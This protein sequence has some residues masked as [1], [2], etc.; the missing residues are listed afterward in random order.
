MKT[1]FCILLFSLLSSNTFAQND[2]QLDTKLIQK[3][4][5]GAGFVIQYEGL[6]DPFISESS[7]SVMYGFSLQRNS[8][9]S[10]SYIHDAKMPLVKLTQTIAPLSNVGNLDQLLEATISDAVG[11]LK[12]LSDDPN[13]ELKDATDFTRIIASTS[14]TGK[15]YKIKINNLPGFLECYAFKDESGKGIGVTVKYLEESNN[16]TS[17]NETNQVDDILDD[18][19]IVSIDENTPYVYQLAQYPLHF[20][21]YSKIEYAK[22]LN[23]SAVE[24]KVQMNGVSLTLQL[25]NIPQ[26]YSTFETKR[27]QINSHET[28]LKDQEMQGT[29]TRNWSAKTH[30][31][32]GSDS[33]DLVEGQ[34]Y[35]YTAN[36]QTIFNT[37][38]TQLNGNLLVIANFTAPEENYRGVLRY[39]ATLFKNSAGATRK[40]QRQYLFPGFKLYLPPNHH[41]WKREESERYD[42]YLISN[43]STYQFDEKFNSVFSRVPVTRLK[44]YGLGE[45]QSLNHS[46]AELLNELMNRMKADD[47]PFEFYKNDEFLISNYTLANE[48]LVQKTSSVIHPQLNI[49][50]Y[51]SLGFDDT[52]LAVTSYLLPNPHTGTM[53]VVSTIS[54]TYLDPS[55]NDITLSLLN[56]MSPTEHISETDLGFAKLHFDPFKYRFYRDI[57]DLDDSRTYFV[58]NSEDR[59]SIFVGNSDPSNEVKSVKLLA[60]T[61]MKHAWKTQT[62]GVNNLLFPED[63]DSLLEVKI[64]GKPGLLFEREITTPMDHVTSQTQEKQLIRV[65][66]FVYQ[67][68]FVSITMK[69]VGENIDPQRL[70]QWINS[71]TE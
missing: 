31:A 9:S 40:N 26:Q 29:L 41:I 67:N 32:T 59:I 61:N 38:Y 47:K 14:Q 45:F 19:Q 13:I 16:D 35:S 68:R 8:L 10:G 27:E 51:R 63:I 58:T 28:M 69:Q 23:E 44:F 11:A 24:M 33:S 21:V 36:N 55:A 4:M 60:E 37:L 39:A 7:N 66:G 15:Q 17:I 71:F 1:I 34:V 64:A 43:Q 2:A 56:K 12:V 54:N 48:T 57:E 52:A 70:D 49:E 5:R 46:H 62:T 30:I 20:P 6:L 42:E 3:N 18:L 53:C 50:L 65:Y 25:I 22:Q